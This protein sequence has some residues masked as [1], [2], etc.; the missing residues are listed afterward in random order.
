MTMQL[1]DLNI[2]VPDQLVLRFLPDGH[3]FDPLRTAAVKT[4]IGAGILRLVL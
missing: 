2:A 3:G 1:E 4:P